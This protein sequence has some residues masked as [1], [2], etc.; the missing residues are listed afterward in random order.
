MSRKHSNTFCAA[1]VAL[2]TLTCSAPIEKDRL[3]GRWQSPDELGQFGQSR[4][5]LCFSSDG[6]VESALESQAGTFVKRGEYLIADHEL[7]LNFPGAEEGTVVVKVR[8]ANDALMLYWPGQRETTYRRI[9]LSC[10]P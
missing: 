3:V 4:N 7:R 6:R 1:V 8:F 2:L 9:G 5:M 10:G